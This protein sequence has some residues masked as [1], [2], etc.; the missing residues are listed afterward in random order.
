MNQVFKM[1]GTTSGTLSWLAPFQSAQDLHDM[2]YCR[3]VACLAPSERCTHLVLLLTKYLSNIQADFFTP[4]NALTTGKRVTDI[5]ITVT[6]L[7]T[8]MKVDIS[9]CLGKIGVP[10]H[11]NGET[12]LMSWLASNYTYELG[13]GKTAT[14]NDVYERNM[15]FAVAMPFQMY[16][17]IEAMEAIKLM[18][19]APNARSILVN[20]AMHMWI[21]CVICHTRHQHIS[22]ISDIT[23]RLHEVERKSIHAESFG[24]FPNYSTEGLMRQFSN[25]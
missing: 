19:P 20:A 5:L 13:P 10:A 25:I 11:V 9:E 14:V 21:Q 15:Q 22:F 24:Y 16:R 2:I 7:L 18:Q 12:A 8:A 23:E 6:S 4:N 3:D 1:P 17:I